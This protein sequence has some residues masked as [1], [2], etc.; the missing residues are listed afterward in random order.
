MK[1][2]LVYTVYVDCIL[3]KSWDCILIKFCLY[4]VRVCM[5]VNEHLIVL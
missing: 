5:C 3:I 2:E 4:D 1:R